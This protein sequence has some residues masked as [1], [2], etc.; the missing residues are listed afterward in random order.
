MLILGG[1]NMK[2]ILLCITLIML[3]VINASAAERKKFYVGLDVGPYFPTGVVKADGYSYELEFDTGYYIGGDFTYY[4]TDYLGIS[5]KLSIIAFDVTQKSIN[6]AGSSTG[7]WGDASAMIISVGGAFRYPISDVIDFTAGAG[8]GIANDDLNLTT[9]SGTD[10]GGDS[11]IAFYIDL[12]GRYYFTENV[13]GGIALKYVVNS[14]EDEIQG[15]KYKADL[16]G[17][18]LLFNVGYSF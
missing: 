14:G 15:D 2:K 8:I 17:A 7:V 10:S 12:G 18:A 9:A 16:S 6:I 4:I 11:P 1:N 13:S 3:F 5:G